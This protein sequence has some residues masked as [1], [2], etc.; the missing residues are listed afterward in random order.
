MQVYSIYPVSL[1]KNMLQ[2]FLFTQ[3]LYINT[4]PFKPVYIPLHTQV[5][6]GR[7]SSP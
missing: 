7:S 4:H 1:Y 5:L 2:A 6:H 3:Y